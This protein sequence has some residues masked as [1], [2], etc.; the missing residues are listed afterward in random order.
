MLTA[1]DFVLTNLVPLVNTNSTCVTSGIVVMLIGT[2]PHS[3]ECRIAV[4]VQVFFLTEAA[5]IA[6]LISPD[7][8]TRLLVLSFYTLELHLQAFCILFRLQQF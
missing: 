2:T 5:N 7:D 4:L 8:D 6:D 1:R 3:L